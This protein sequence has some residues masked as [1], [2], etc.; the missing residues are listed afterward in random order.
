M[1]G[2]ALL[3]DQQ[4][5]LGSVSVWSL[6]GPLVI[7]VVVG[8]SLVWKGLAGPKLPTSN[9]GRA[10]QH[11]NHM[12]SVISGSTAVFNGL[13]F[14]GAVITDD[15]LIDATTIFG[16]TDII[17]SP[18]MKVQLNSTRIFCGADNHAATPQNGTPGPLSTCVRGR[19]S[20]ASTSR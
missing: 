4:Q 7:V 11:G 5:L 2:A 17:V 13:P 8:G 14:T 10:M 16:G 6:V 19:R 12:S 1:I 18:G 20:G 3:A 15:V 9:E